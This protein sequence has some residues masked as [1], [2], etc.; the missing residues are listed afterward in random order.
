MKPVWTSLLLLLTGTVYA[1]PVRLASG[2]G[3]VHLL[4]LF[5]SEGCSSCP[6][7]ERWLGT[8]RERPGLWSDFVP[9][10]YHVSYWDHLG[11]K[12]RWASR[13]YTERQ[14][15]YAAAW[16]TN[17]VYTPCLVTDGAET[18]VRALPSPGG[19]APRLEVE[20]NGS[21]GSVT[22]G[23]EQDCEVHVALLGGGIVSAVKAGENRGET[24]R[25]EFVVLALSRFPI[26]NGR[27][28]ITVPVVDTTGVTRQALAVWLTRPGS[29][30]VLQAVGGWLD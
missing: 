23:L 10:A 11:W 16:K 29:A 12:D 15:G 6:P 30:E 19:I 27:A 2:P 8:L 26:A 17:S 20:L 22:W 7:A 24:L 21:N 1:E 18:R 13:E 28:Q 4:E 5:T 9:L 25:H 14:Y 3:R